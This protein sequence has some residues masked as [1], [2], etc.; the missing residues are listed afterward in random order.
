MTR[1]SGPPIRSPWDP[2]ADSRQP[3]AGSAG[4]TCRP[5]AGTAC[6]LLGRERRTCAGWD[7]RPVALA[8]F[9]TEAA[10]LAILDHSHI[11]LI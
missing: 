3:V 8:R 9:A 6:S 4:S 1:H 11:V 5:E 10:L 7:R 2:T